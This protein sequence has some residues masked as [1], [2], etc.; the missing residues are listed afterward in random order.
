MPSADAK[1]LSS[2]AKLP[3]PSRGWG[4]KKWLHVTKTLS[5]WFLALNLTW[6]KFHVDRTS[7]RTFSQPS[8]R[9]LTRSQGTCHPF[10]D[11]SRN[12]ERR[13]Y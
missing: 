10:G 2:G 6:P 9:R 12:I 11:A 13:N 7:R 5:P 1:P 8:A 4:E 3:A